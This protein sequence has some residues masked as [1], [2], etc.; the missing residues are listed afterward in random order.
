MRCSST[1][2]SPASPVTSRSSATPRTSTSAAHA[3]SGS[4]PTPSSPWT[5]SLDVRRAAPSHRGGATNLYVHLT[6]AD[7][8][9][10]FD[11]GHR[12]RLDREARRGHHPAAHRL[13]H[14]VRRSRHQDHP[15]PGPRP[16][17][18]SG[19]RP[20]RPTR[21]D[22]RN[23]DAARRDL[24]LPQMLPRLPGLRPRPHHRIP[25]HGRRR[26]TGPEPARIS[27]RCAEPIIAPRPTPPGT[28]N[29]SMTAAMRGPRPPATSTEL[30][31][32]RVVRHL[33]SSD[34]SLRSTTHRSGPLR[35]LLL[36]P[37][38]V[39]ERA[40]ASVSKPHTCGCDR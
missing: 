17:L 18:G 11:R 37:P 8:V 22:A 35:A 24:R 32:L 2:P 39:E 20:A 12:G 15:P 23:R 28:T 34:R 10:D 6:P 4:S 9:A 27:R 36:L 14:P 5:S 19:R 40:P 13:A 38:V 21:S 25:T 29:A 26:T 16:Q 3:R 7:L 33:V 30:P 31:L 1:R